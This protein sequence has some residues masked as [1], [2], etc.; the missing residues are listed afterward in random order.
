MK[1]NYA[2]DLDDDDSMPEGEEAGWLTSY[3]DLMSLL[4]VFFV[5]MM[6]ASQVSRIKYEKIKN[7]VSGTEDVGVTKDFATVAKVLNKQVESNDLQEKV[8]IE[9]LNDSIKITFSESLLFSSGQATILEQ[10]KQVLVKLMRIL[11]DLPDYAKIT[12]E[13]HTD[14]VPIRGGNFRNNW[15]LSGIRALAVV[16]LLEGE[17]DSGRISFRGFG[18]QKPLVPNQTESGKAI[19]KNQAKNRRVVIRIH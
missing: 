11:K 12:V 13:G 10:N 16:E 6:S 14:N 19:K 15:H 7:A 2:W 4:L 5:L 3:G 17:I 1:R 8:V 9:D 18:A